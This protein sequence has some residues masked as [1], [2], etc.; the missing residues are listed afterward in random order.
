MTCCGLVM[1]TGS[2]SHLWAPLSLLGRPR[3]VSKQECNF[4]R[5]TSRRSLTTR[6]QLEL[7]PLTGPTHTK[8][9]DNICQIRCGYA[10]GSTQSFVSN[11]E[12]S[13][14]QAALVKRG[15]ESILGFTDPLSCIRAAVELLLTS[16]KNAENHCIRVL[17][18]EVTSI[19]E[20]HAKAAYRSWGVSKVCPMPFFA[21][22][23]SKGED[24]Q[25]STGPVA[26]ISW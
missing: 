21:C 25:M 13:T 18:R 12:I 8:Y 11:S 5:T 23:G 10:A 19:A 22:I 16:V 7:K 3:S 4:P 26:A 17:I 6:A 9:T 14:G 24:R 2:A 15:P 20:K 1:Y